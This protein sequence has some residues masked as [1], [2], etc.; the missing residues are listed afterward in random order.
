MGRTLFRLGSLYLS[1]LTIK[2]TGYFVI[3]I[4]PQKDMVFELQRRGMLKL[5]QKKFKY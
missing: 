4:N 3:K 5:A 1:T 2:N